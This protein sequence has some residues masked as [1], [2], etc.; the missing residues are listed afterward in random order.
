MPP[1]HRPFYSE[2]S[3]ELIQ[4]TNTEMDQS[5]GQIKENSVT[6]K[7]QYIDSQIKSQVQAQVQVQVQIQAFILAQNQTRPM[8]QSIPLEPP[9]NQKFVSHNYI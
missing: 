2:P 1:R 8:N 9:A 7:K 3:A 5:P 6:P 4:E